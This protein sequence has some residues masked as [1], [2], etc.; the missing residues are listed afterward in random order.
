MQGDKLCPKCG[1]LIPR[2]TADCPLC[3]N[4]LGFSV[5]R[6]TWLLVCFGMLAV[7]FAVT[8]ILVK[9]Y[10]ARERA[11]ARQWYARGKEK[12]S[13]GNPQDAV[14]DFRTALFHSEGNPDYQLQLA[15][16]LVASGH[17]DEARTYLVR[18]WEG[19]PASGP[20]NLE[21]ARLAVRQADVAKV[22]SYY[23]N[24]ID[25]VWPNESPSTPIELRKQ[26]C[27]YLIEHGRHAD[28]LAELIALSSVTPEDP[29]PLTEV[30][31][32]F[33]K[34]QDYDGALKEY[35]R[36]LRL[37]HRHA[38]AWAGA[39]KAAFM[40]GDYA[41]ARHYLD[42]ALARNPRDA[43]S[44][45]LRDTAIEVL[46]IDPY[47]RRISAQER[48]R[49]AVLDFDHALAQLTA[50]AQ[51][52]GVNLKVAND[53]SGLESLYAAAMKMKPQMRESLLRRNPDLVDSAMSLVFQI[54]Q[55]LAQK[56]AAAG[57][58]D[59]ALLLI[60]QKNGGAS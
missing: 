57:S 2:G 13:H 6:E 17:E 43:A 46:E 11:L 56:C 21:L 3:A 18:L 45:Q 53:T 49:R 34:A 59:R 39:G 15:Q 16:A 42:S 24:A 1:Q 27:E 5:R 33:L 14:P 25:G 30:A 8:G 50:C 55:A 58:M 28:A 54:E 19:D 22:I 4:P 52:Q 20:V 9:Q 41:L 26:L 51:A 12:L 35:L 36:A 48:R 38:A 60:G 23:H 37:S 47:D 10:H 32:L 29:R 31:D 7:L 40:M 44:A